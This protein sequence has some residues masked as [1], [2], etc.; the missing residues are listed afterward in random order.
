MKRDFTD[1]TFNVMQPLVDCNYKLQSLF[2]DSDPNIIAD[3][4]TQGLRE[5]TDIMVKKQHFQVKNCGVQYWNMEW[6]NE[7]KELA[8]LNK[9][10]IKMRNIK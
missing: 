10:A 9:I 5:I 3:K 1:C 2:T 8:K 7:R 6:E 4:L